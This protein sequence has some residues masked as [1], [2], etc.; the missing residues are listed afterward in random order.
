MLSSTLSS[1]EGGKSVKLL[2]LAFIVL[3]SSCGKRQV[4]TQQNQ[5]KRNDILG[6]K[7]TSNDAYASVVQMVAKDITGHGIS[8]CSGTLICEN[9][10]QC[11]RSKLIKTSAHCFINE[12]FIQMKF[13]EI[14]K[15]L[16]KSGALKVISPTQIMIIEPAFSLVV[17]VILYKHINQF[18]KNMEIRSYKAKKIRTHDFESVRI[19]PKWISFFREMLVAGMKNDEKQIEKLQKQMENHSGLDQAFLKIKKPIRDIKI[20]RAATREEVEEYLTEGQEIT[21]AGWGLNQ[22]DF[23]FGV[24]SFGQHY[25]HPINNKRLETK[26]KVR[27]NVDSNGF[28]YVGGF[29]DWWFGINAYQNGACSGDSGGGAFMQIN[30]EMKHI[31]TITAIQPGLCGTPIPVTPDGNAHHPKDE[32]HTT[33]LAW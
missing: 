25:K 7:V 30:G 5:I 18:V 14:Q 4:H 16:Q 21:I 9:E 3:L 23:N 11:K 27:K 31:G 1:L 6:D 17:E 22:D 20:Y 33:I 24:A 13:Q 28:F 29:S 26:V 8:A 32:Y 10:R 15:D 2:V 19:H 12:E